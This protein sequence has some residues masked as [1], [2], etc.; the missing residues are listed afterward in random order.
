LPAT[1]LKPTILFCWIIKLKR[2]IELFFFLFPVVFNM[3]SFNACIILTGALSLYDP[4]LEEGA[5]HQATVTIG[6]RYPAAMVCT[7]FFLGNDNKQR[8]FYHRLPVIFFFIVWFKVS[9]PVFAG[10]NIEPCIAVLWRTGYL[11]K[12]YSEQRRM[13][14][15]C[16]P[17]W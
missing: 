1:S 5:L 4:D 16:L 3:H 15:Q 9:V 7:I 12:G 8:V 11:A 10:I 6:I 2:V 14:W 13:V 17:G